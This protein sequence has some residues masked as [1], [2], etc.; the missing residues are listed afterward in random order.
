I[1]VVLGTGEVPQIVRAINGVDRA[2]GGAPVTFYGS[3]LQREI[4]STLQRQ[5][6]GTLQRE[7]PSIL[8][9]QRPTYLYDASTPRTLATPR[10]Y[11]YVKIAEGC[12]YKCAF[13]IIPTL[14]GAYRSRPADSIVTEARRLAAAGVK[15][16]LLISQD[17]TF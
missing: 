15:E 14:R 11:A 2:A 1:D 16:L 4:P 9:R 7:S 12:D 3:T 8:E 13:C 5:F 10:H 17:T 6:H